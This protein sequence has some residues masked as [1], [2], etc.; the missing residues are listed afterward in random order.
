MELSVQLHIGVLHTRLK[1]TSGQTGKP[2]PEV[3][4]VCVCVVV[5]V[6]VY[7]CVTWKNVPAA[8]KKS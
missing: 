6:V 1:T 5:C 2:R 3:E 8:K 4:G 7:V